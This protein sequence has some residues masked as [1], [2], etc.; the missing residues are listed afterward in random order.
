MSRTTTTAM[1]GAAPSAKS[2]LA[3]ESIR[4]AADWA[5]AVLPTEAALSM[6]RVAAAKER[7][8]VLDGLARVLMDGFSGL[9]IRP[10]RS[11]AALVRD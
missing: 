9:D 6:A 1:P 7:R 3:T 11:P 4:A 10:E 5:D 2:E 8:W